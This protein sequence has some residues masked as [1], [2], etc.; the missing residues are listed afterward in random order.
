MAQAAS[1]STLELG[2]RIDRDTLGEVV[3]EAFVETGAEY[4]ITGS[5]LD[6]TIDKHASVL[7]YEPVDGGVEYRVDLQTPEELQE[8]G[9]VKERSRLKGTFLRAGIA[10]HP[11]LGAVMRR[12]REQDDVIIGVDT[13]VLWDCTLTSSLL[14]EIYAE[15]FPNWIL[16]AVP[17]LVMA[18]TENAANAKISHG[19][20]PRVGWPSYRGRVG[21]RALQ[22]S[23]DI[24]KPDVD[25]PGLAMMSIGEISQDTSE[26]SEDNWRIDALI[27]DQ[28]KKFLGDINFHKGTY[29]LSQDRVNVMMSGTEGTQGLY[30]QKP[31]L[32]DFGAGTVSQDHLTRL[33]VELCLQFGEITIE[34]IAGD[35]SITLEVFWPGKRVEDWRNGRLNVCAVDI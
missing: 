18:E 25:R 26:F 31:E 15:Q 16:I 4:V 34:D 3:A 28:F 12:L 29:F 11:N 1:V 21:H 33:I 13:N 2:D 22:E 20:H 6:Y 8:D 9:E 19:A 32:D 23:M 17:R 5:L 24:R 30:L 7:R 10:T 35:R 27:R 14:E